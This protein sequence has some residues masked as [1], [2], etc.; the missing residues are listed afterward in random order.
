MM[1]RGGSYS[2]GKK[3]RE[4]EKARKKQEKTEKR[5]QRRERGPGE[6]MELA[7]AEEM[8]GPLRSVD[9]VLQALEGGNKNARAAAPIPARLFVGGLSW[10]TTADDLRKAFGEFGVVS[11]A[12]VVTDRA[13]G[14]SKGFGFVT[15]QDRK[16]G[17]R[18]IEQMHDS[19]LDGRRIVVN[20]ATERS[21]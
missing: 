17:A 2:Q 10:G 6:E 8:T 1:A 7:T 18:A 5:Q 21:R 9:E 16:D 14:N 13:T 11:D 15:M 20:A 12:V 4:Q 3:Q 19:E